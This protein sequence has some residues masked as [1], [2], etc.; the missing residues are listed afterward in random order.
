MTW[1]GAHK[2]L[3]NIG[4]G[5]SGPLHNQGKMK[6]TVVKIN[7]PYRSPRGG[8]INYPGETISV[9][10]EEAERLLIDRDA[11]MVEIGSKRQKVSKPVDAPADL[12]GL[13]KLHWLRREI[14]DRGG[15]PD[16]R[17]IAA[18]TEQLKGL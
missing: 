9:T 3:C 12:K 13:A 15:V 11:E 10:P 8:A 18:L 5:C 1:N 16:G 6:M 17:T 14:K 7:K 2:R 4:A